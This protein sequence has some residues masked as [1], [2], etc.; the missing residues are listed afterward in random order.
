VLIELEDVVIVD[1]NVGRDS[2]PKVCSIEK[3]SRSVLP[4]EPAECQFIL[5]KWRVFVI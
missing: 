1:S 2:I 5:G 3:A 4:E